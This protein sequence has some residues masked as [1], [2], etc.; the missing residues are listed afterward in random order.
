MNQ[1]KWIICDDKRGIVDLISKV[2]PIHGLMSV[3]QGKPE[4]VRILR[5]S[6]KTALPFR[7]SS[8]TG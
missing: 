8:L 1:K 2:T 4:E 5:A 3:V 7:P 6:C